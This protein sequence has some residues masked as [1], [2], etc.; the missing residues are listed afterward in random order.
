MTP[1]NKHIDEIVA[2]FV[3]QFLPKIYDSYQGWTVDCFEE[4]E[5]FLRSSLEEVY[6]R[7]REENRANVTDALNLL[8]DTWHHDIEVLGAIRKLRATLKTTLESLKKKD[9]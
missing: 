6:E 1:P 2:K 7:G 3:E 4:T 5:S 8:E 9:L